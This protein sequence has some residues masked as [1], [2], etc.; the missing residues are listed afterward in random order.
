MLRQSFRFITPVARTARV[1][2]IC[3][4]SFITTSRV[5]QEAKQPTIKTAKNLAEV[6]GSESLVGPGTQPGN[7]PTDLEQAT[8]LERLELLGK[9]EGIE[10]F[11]LKPLDSSRK[12]TMKDPIVV[13]SYD[14]Y[15]YIG[16]TGSPADSHTIMWLKAT[17]GREARCWECGSVY[18]LK[19]VGVETEDDHH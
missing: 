13:E 1:S 12:G 11:D 8:G 6:N 7:I 2:P 18:K 15:R 5:L 16:C 19:K 9:L 17:E 14:D 3:R 10:V 4:R